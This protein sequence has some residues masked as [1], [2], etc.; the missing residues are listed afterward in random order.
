MSE[1]KVVK[2]TKEDMERQRQIMNQLRV[3]NEEYFRAKGRRKT[4][5]VRT[6]GCEMN[7]LRC[8]FN[9]LLFSIHK[10]VF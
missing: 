5:L 1:R 7:A 8:F 6:Y 2:V 9:S 3:R 10:P 4:V